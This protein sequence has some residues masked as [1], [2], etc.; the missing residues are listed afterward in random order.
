[1]LV[2]HCIPVAAR[3]LYLN[4][5]VSTANESESIR[6][7]CEARGS[8]PMTIIWSRSIDSHQFERLSTSKVTCEKKSF[9]DD[10]ICSSIETILCMIDVDSERMSGQFEIGCHAQNYIIEEASS[11]SVEV[12]FQGSY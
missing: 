10:G 2:Q 1:M 9:S 11:K 5:D 12:V 4:A 6:I 7:S 8:P 3:V